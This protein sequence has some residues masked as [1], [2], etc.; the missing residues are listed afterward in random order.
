MAPDRDH[1]SGARGGRRGD[2][3]ARA[4][5]QGRGEQRLR[6]ADRLRGMRSEEHTSEL[7]SLMRISYAAFCLKKK[8]T[9]K[10]NN[11]Y[12]KN[13]TGTPQSIQS[14]NKIINITQR[15]VEIQ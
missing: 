8:K 15:Q 9:N 7:Q 10:T 1:I 2:L 3:D 11:I 14:L 6:A 13:T 5:G 12:T 4:I